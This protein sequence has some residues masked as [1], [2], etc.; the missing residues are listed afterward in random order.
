MAHTHSVIDDDLHFI[1][2]PS[3]REIGNGSQKV[4]LMQYD[5]NS[6]Q[7]TFEIPRFVEGHDMSLCNSIRV[8]YININKS[9][10]EQH[11]GVYE[12][13][14]IKVEEDNVIFSWLVSRNATQ[15]VGPLN[16]L[17]KF[18]CFDEDSNVI[19]E[20][21]TDIFKSASV[22]T[23]MNNEESIEEVYPDILEKWKNDVL[24]EEASRVT[25]ESERV[26]AE[27]ERVTAESER[28]TAE[29]ERVTAESER[30]TAESERVTAESERA[31]AESERATAESERATAESER[32]TAESERVTA[33]SE[34]ANAFAGYETEINQFKNEIITGKDSATDNTKFAI[35]TAEQNLEV[36]S[37]EEFNELKG[38]KVDKDEIFNAGIRSIS[39]APLFGGSFT[40]TTV[41]EEGY[42]KPHAIAT[43]TGRISKHYTYRVTINEEEYVLPCCLFSTRNNSG[44]V[45]EYL[46]NIELYTSDISGL[47]QDAIHNVPFCIIS[48]LDGNNSIDVFTRS[49][50]EVSITVER[51]QKEQTPL[52]KSLIWGDDYCPIELKKNENS[53]FNGL[54]IGCNILKNSRGTFAIGYGN[55]ISHEFGIAIGY[56]NTS[57]GYCSCAEGCSNTSSGTYS[58][59]GGFTTTASGNVSH[60]EG[61]NATA[62]GFNSHAEGAFTT[63]SGQCSH[64]EGSVSNAIGPCSHAAGQATKANGAMSHVGGN[65]SI[66]DGRAS[67][68]HGNFSKATQPAQFAVG[69]GNDPQEDSIF[70]VG[71]GLNADGAPNNAG[72]TEPVTRQNAFRVTQSGVAIAQTGLQIGNTVISEDQLKK[73]LTLIE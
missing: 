19:Y 26:T 38:D 6:E 39:Y 46:G 60:A 40:V 50:C 9:N 33:E 53:T 1:I 41:E 24:A 31:T 3:T 27:S 5:H 35:G 69:Y 37:M 65:N 72:N 61:F 64:A 68:A 23:G 58:Y 47:M 10:R 57:S 51:M 56:D 8:N 62:S 70:E 36:P 4:K 71:N 54:S 15:Y 48:D 44:E 32:A 43:V 49:P 66:T 2:D 22:S 16:F 21:H 18:M 59:A 55:E 63:A 34:R 14:D 17:I 45:F 73:I 20:W 12:V 52:P 11:P 29:S 13:R 28:V 25:A 67:F 42:I 7:F 30:A